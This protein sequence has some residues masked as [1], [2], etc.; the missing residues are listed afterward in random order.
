M[1]VCKKLIF[2]PVKF[3]FP[4]IAA[5]LFFCSCQTPLVIWDSSIPEEKLSTV[6]F[7]NMTI[8]SYNGI[9]VSKFYRAKIPAGEAAFSGVVTIS[10]GGVRF[11]ARNMEFS[12]FFEEG[13]TYSLSGGTGNG[14]W[15]INVFEDGEMLVFIPFKVQPK[16]T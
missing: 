5:F 14:L 7:Y 8:E 3:L 12:C 6:E 9:N 13:K 11:V 16:F 10:H 2:S 1:Q 15:G 4:A